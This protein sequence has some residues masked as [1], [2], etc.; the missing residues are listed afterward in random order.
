MKNRVKLTESQL[1]K[2]ITKIIK[3]EL[4]NELDDSTM[5]SALRKTGRD[6][7]RQGQYNRMSKNYSDR[8]FGKFI[9]KELL[10]ATILRVQLNTSD[11]NYG[12][13]NFNRSFTI[14][15]RTDKHGERYAYYDYHTDSLSIEGN[16]Y[17]KVSRRDAI[18]LC[19]MISGYNPDTIYQINNIHKLF[20]IIDNMT[21]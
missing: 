11:N 19:K 12:G 16:E 13:G 21:E 10:G 1:R 5:Q 2:T 18:L 6:N 4:M 17:N 7:N 20:K 14:T 8:F 15:M 3:E 9:G